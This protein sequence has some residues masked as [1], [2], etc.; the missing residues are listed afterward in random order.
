M[1]ISALA[2]VPPPSAPPRLDAAT[3]GSSFA[4]ALASQQQLEA[5]RGV[6]STLPAPIV[7][8]LR[9]GGG[10]PAEA[11]D[12]L[13]E[14]L[15]DGSFTPPDGPLGQPGTIIAATAHATMLFDSP[16]Q[17]WG[18]MRSAIA[19]PASSA[20]TLRGAPPSTPAPPS[21]EP[22]SAV[23]EVHT[24]EDAERLLTQ[25]RA[26]P[27]APAVPAPLAMTARD[28]EWWLAA[29]RFLLGPAFEA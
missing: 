21:A 12:R 7:Y 6:L 25:L 9:E 16:S 29:L 2:A 24:L 23:T 20:A 4:G 8:S 19:D 5:A 17:L 15:K 11:V 10:S 22:L 1:E 26:S 13:F 3:L 14:V 18:A 27:V 28:T